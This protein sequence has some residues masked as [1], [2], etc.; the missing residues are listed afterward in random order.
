MNHKKLKK[1]NNSEFIKTSPECL[2][3]QCIQYVAE[4]LCCVDSF[5]GLPDLIGEQIFKRAN[6]LDK[7]NLDDKSSLH[8]LAI[9][10]NPYEE[11]VASSLNLSYQHLGINYCQDHINLFTALREIDLTGCKL[12]DN[13][14]LMSHL[15][16]LEWYVRLSIC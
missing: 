12:G 6:S 7:F 11:L 4:H 15:G 14:D 9:F 16:Q 3:S 5:F 8:A 1:D 10:T 2:L 13:H